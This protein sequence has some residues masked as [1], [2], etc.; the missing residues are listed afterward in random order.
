MSFLEKLAEK[1]MG[2]FEKKMD[3]LKKVLEN[4]DK[5]LEQIIALLKGGKK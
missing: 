3:E 2:K 5:K 4:I 1:K